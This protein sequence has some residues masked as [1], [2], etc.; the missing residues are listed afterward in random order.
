LCKHSHKLKARRPVLGPP[1][2]RGSELKFTL[3]IVQEA[4][5]NVA[6][7]AGVS[8]V[9]VRLWARQDILGVQ[10]EDQGI[11]FDPEAVLAA[12][13]TSGLLR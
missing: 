12:G 2:G 3:M 9:T 7:Y 13:I 10:I 5:T 6:R 8:E 1:R 4:L 11:S